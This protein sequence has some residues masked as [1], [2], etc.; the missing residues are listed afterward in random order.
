VLCSTRGVVDPA[1]ILG[2][3]LFSFDAAS[4]H[5]QWLKEA[6]LGEHKPESLE[7][8]VSSISFRS[9]RPFH[10]ARFN[11]AIEQMQNKQV[12][13]SACLIIGDGAVCK[14]VPFAQV[15]RAKGTVWPATA[16]GH[17]V[18]ITCQFAGKLAYFE[19][20]AT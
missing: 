9:F 13:Q 3:G 17:R 16:I 8:G 20:A 10:P 14:Q 6:R 11:A 7:Y 4:K 18:Q 2:T 19:V 5:P 1:N 15:I 12:P